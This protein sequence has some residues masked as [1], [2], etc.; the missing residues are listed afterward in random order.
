MKDICPI[1]R[2]EDDI[3]RS[4]IYPKFMWK[5][6]KQTGGT[7]FRSV[8]NPTKE[9]QN[10]II[11]DLLGA[12]AEQMFSKRELW[13]ERNIFT[14]YVNGDISLK[15]IRYTEEL[16]YFCVS[17]LWRFLYIHQEKVISPYLKKTVIEALEDWR[18][19][20]NEEI[21][22][23]DKFPNIY[24][25]PLSPDILS[26]PEEVFEIDFYLKREFDGNIMI[27][28]DSKD[29]AVYCKFPRFVVWGQL[30]REDTSIN[31][32]MRVLP[33]GGILNF[34][35][36]HV[37]P[38]VVRNY[39]IGKISESDE[40]SDKMTAQLSDKVQDT[41]SKRLLSNIDRIKDSELGNLL[42]ERCK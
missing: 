5:F 1:T 14:P 7:V 15:K 12:Q 2:K 4:H 17:I 25:M 28:T 33:N 38:G 13:F 35:T 27:A 29:I 24:M 37:A 8:E 41:I 20:L 31:Y 10:G 23:P 3:R 40:I 22:Y 9:L 30:A 11:L 16:F 32:G 6:L 19:F 26:L 21:S 42:L 36:F 34:K 39:V 18:A